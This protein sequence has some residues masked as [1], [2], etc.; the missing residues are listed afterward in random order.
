MKKQASVFVTA[1][2]A[3]SGAFAFAQADLLTRLRVSASEANDQI[4]YTLTSGSASL[5]GNA[6]AFKSAAPDARALMAKG[7]VALARTYASSPA[8]A[9]RY[10]QERQN[11]KPEA[12]EPRPSAADLATQQRK[13]LEE[14][15]ANAQA[16]AAANPAMKK[17]MDA[18]VVEL[19]KQLA[20]VGKDAGL[21]AQMEAA[22][23]AQA[24]ED[25]A[26][27]KQDLAKWEQDWPADPKALII[28]RLRQ[29]LEVSATV[30]FSAKTELDGSTRRYRFANPEYEDKDAQWKLMFRAGKP[31][32]DAARAAALE[33]LKALGA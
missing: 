17:D 13:G 25:Q 33:W 24:A 4:F 14:A 6:S 26:R 28:T 7:V 2:L 10:S 20:Q 29:F 5:S 21:N 18:L 1:T 9:T 3:L 19:R 11:A 32:V 16:M 23:K 27:Y 22:Q 31:A 12:P 8:F 15:I 30:D